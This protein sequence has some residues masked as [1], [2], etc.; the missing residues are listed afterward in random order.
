MGYGDVCCSWGLPLS[1]FLFP[2]LFFSSSFFFLVCFVLGGRA[3][4]VTNKCGEPGWPD[5]GR[6]ALGYR[7]DVGLRGAGAG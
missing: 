1:F 3:E 4:C 2:F 7:R 6:V 5:E